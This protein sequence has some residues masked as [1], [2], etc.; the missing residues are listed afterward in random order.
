M[1]R[2]TIDD[3]FRQLAENYAVVYERRNDGS[4]RVVRV[5]VFG[6]SDASAPSETDSGQ[7]SAP[8]GEIA[9]DRKGPAGKMQMQAAESSLSS[10]TPFLDRRGRPRFRR[11]ELLVRSKPGVS[12]EET[13][14][15]HASLGSRVISSMERR[16]LQKVALRDGL[17]EEEAIRLY[18]ASSLVEN[19]EKH[20]LRYA[21]GLEPNDPFYDDQWGLP[22][23]R[24]P[25]AW[26]AGKDLPD[27]VVAVIDSG[28]DYLHPDL[29]E[30]MWVN[31]VEVNGVP[32][33]D[34]DENGCVDDYHG[35]DF[36]GAYQFS[37]YDDRDG[38]P[39]DVDGHGTHVAGIVGARVSNNIG[40][41]GVAWNAR[42]MALKVQ[43]DNS[44][45]EMES[46]DIVG[47]IDYA[48]SE[49][50]KIVNCSFGGEEDSFE[51]RSAFSSL[52]VAGILAIC[53]AGNDGEDI[54][55]TPMYPASYASDNIITVAA[56]DQN[57]ALADFSNY[58]A[59][60]V[61][62]MAPG[63]SILSAGDGCS[64]TKA[65]V[66]FRS[67]G[68]T[69]IPSRYAW[70]M[71]YAGTTSAEGLTGPAHDCGWGYPNEFP[72]G[73]QDFI[74]IVKRGPI[75]SPLYFHEKVENAVN[76]GAAGVVVYDH[77]PGTDSFC[78]T[79]GGG[80]DWIPVV[81][82][83]KEDGEAILSL[84][85]PLTATLINSMTDSLSFYTHKSGT[86][87]AAPAVAGVAAMMLGREPSLDYR[88][89][90]ARIL[91]SVQPIPS[92][93]GKILSEGRVDAF[94]ALCSARNVLGDLSCDGNIQLDDALISMQLTAGMVHPL[95]PSCIPSG[96]DVSGDGRI[97]TEETIFILQQIAD[98]GN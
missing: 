37:L 94:S 89:L 85:P 22:L 43:A 71:V 47:A 8:M 61:D 24:A 72:A 16:R 49:D 39:I 15:L 81:F 83:P 68:Q 6:K 59:I 5:G 60:A 3:F 97:G 87:M 58:G 90:K 40:T 12:A 88:E 54:D 63:A 2:S 91:G 51:E 1:E 74:A 93:S 4:Y 7:P 77:T 36:A 84:S 13:D 86:S 57:D 42:L 80:R 32:G 38:D 98:T 76:A 62:V 69:I 33:W 17:E 48:I 30:A 34:D 56:G 31:K 27:V 79:L 67:S 29:S 20:A 55:V 50:V 95:C 19:A 45:E 96:L 26:A 21:N 66:T 46:W 23:I 11:G 44:G 35:C 65:E 92:L 28:V 25:E 41:A 82:I 64:Y 53:A 14:K 78:G 75:D 18:T 70:G 73:M 10:E 52:Q 9:P